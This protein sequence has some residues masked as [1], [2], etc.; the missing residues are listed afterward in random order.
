MNH[1]KKWF[2]VGFFEFKNDF[3]Q[4]NLDSHQHCMFCKQNNFFW[5]SWKIVKLFG[6][7]GD[8]TQV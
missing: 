6:K 1:M 5:Y 4:N 7:K 3:L 2:R 8:R